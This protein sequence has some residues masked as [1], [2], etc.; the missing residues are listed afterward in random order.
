MSLKSIY[1]SIEN[2]WYDFVEKTGLYKITD[3][4]DKFMPSMLFFILL[5]I[6]IIA[7]IFLLLPISPIGSTNV[8]LI[9]N[10]LE[11]NQ[12]IPSVPV[13]LTGRVSGRQNF[14]T[15]DNGELNFSL[16]KD[17][18]F[19]IDIDYASGNYKRVNNSYTYNDAK[20]GEI[21][22]LLEKEDSTQEL[23]N[24][25]FSLVDEYN[26]RIQN[27]G[28]VE[29]TCSNNNVL[30]PSD[31]DLVNGVVEVLADPNCG[32]RATIYAQGYET[33]YNRLINTETTVISTISTVA[34]FEEDDTYYTI[35]AY[36]KDQITSE[37][38]ENIKFSLYTSTGLKV[39]GSE[40]VTNTGGT[41]N[42]TGVLSG[43]YELRAQ[44]NRTNPIYINKSSN[45]NVNYDTTQT[46]YLSR[47]ITG[48][49]K[50]KVVGNNNIPMD[51]VLLTLKVQDQEISSGRTD[52]NGE[53]L[54]AVSNNGLGYRVVADKE[55]Y[56]IESKAVSAVS[57]M[58]VSPNITIRLTQVTEDTVA[59]INIRV[60]NGNS[61]K[62]YPHAQ[63][64]LY[65]A[66]TGFL[67]DYQA[68]ITDFDGNVSF[69]VA[70][71]KYYA[72]AIKGSS[73][74]KSVDFTFDPK[75]SEI[76]PPVEVV[77]DVSKGQLL[78]SIVNKDN[79]PVPNAKVEIYDKYNRYIPAVGGQLTDAQGLIALDLD[80]DLDVYVVAS[81]PL[82][83]LGITQSDYIKI[84]PNQEA[85]LKVTLY[86]PRSAISNPE[87]EFLGF[88]RGENKLDG[89]L[90]AGQE[91]KARFV[92]FVPSNRSS[93]ESFREVG[94]VI[95][96]GN[97]NSPYLEND[98]IYI[99]EIDVPGAT[100]EKY[101]QYSSSQGYNDKEDV[102]TR[103]LGD[104]KWAKIVIED[105]DY[106]DQE[107]ATAYEIVATVKVRD[108][109]LFGE[110]VEINYLGYG[111][112]RDYTY[113]TD[114][115]YDGSE[116][117][118][119][120]M[121]Y[122]TTPFNI[123]D[124]IVCDDDFCFT[125]TITDIA[126]DLREDVVSNYT[127]APQKDYLLNFGLTNNNNS[128][129]YSQSRF[130]LENEDEG[131]YFVNMNL[132]LP[133]DSQINKTPEAN[134]YN[135]DIATGEFMPRTN[136][137]GEIR[138][139]PI[140]KGDRQIKLEMVSD[141]KVVF[142]KNITIHSLSD[143]TFLVDITPKVIPSGKNF[144]LELEV[145]DATKQI[146][147]NQEVTVTVKDR[148]K[149]TIAGPVTVGA[150]G[151]VSVNNIPGQESGNK[152]YVYVQSPEYE[153]HVSE[154]TT[155]DSIYYITPT[156]LGVSLN[157]NDKTSQDITL[158]IENISE[159][160][161]VVDKI[162]LVGDNDQLEVI[163]VVRIN[164]E[165]LSFIG[166]EIK[167]VDSDSTNNY[168]SKKTFDFSINTNARIQTITELQNL[169]AKIL[170]SL[171]D[172]R[173]SNYVWDEEI[174]LSITV[175][176]DGMFDNSACLTMSEYSIKEVVQSGF[177]EKQFTLKNDCAIKQIPVPLL[178]GLSAKVEFDGTPNGR[179]ILTVGNRLVELSPAY[180][181]TIYDTVDSEKKYPVKL[182]FEPSGRFAGK[183]T[184]KIIFRSNNV[185]TAGAQE[186][187]NSFNFE[188][189]VVN[190]SDC[191]SIPKNVLTINDL[192]KEDSFTIENKGC[193]SET[194][195]RLSCD[196][197]QG[198][199]F[200][201]RENI[202]VSE[203]GT[204]E[205]IKVSALGLTPGIY[206][207]NVHSKIAGAR[208]AEK[209]VGKIR[210][211]VR[212]GT[213]CLDLERYEFDLYRS[214]YSENT[215]LLVNAKSYD[216]T[217]I[218]NRC[219]GQ[220]V[221]VEGKADSGAKW[222]MAILAG[223]RDGLFTGIGSFGLQELG[224]LIGNL[225]G[226]KDK[227]EEK[228]SDKINADFECTGEIK[229][230]QD[231]TTIVC[232][233]NNPI[234]GASY[235]WAIES[236]DGSVTRSSEHI[237]VPNI[238]NDTL[239]IALT[240]K[241]AEKSDKK[242]KEIT[243]GCEDNLTW[244]PAKSICVVD[245]SN[246]TVQEVIDNEDG[247]LNS[248]NPS[249]EDALNPEDAVLDPTLDLWNPTFVCTG[250]TIEGDESS[251]ELFCSAITDKE[252]V[253]YNWSITPSGSE[254]I[255]SENTTISANLS[256]GYVDVILTVS[257]GEEEKTAQDEIFVDCMIGYMWDA[258][259]N[260]C[261]DIIQDPESED[262]TFCESEGYVTA[263]G[264]PYAY[265][266]VSNN[267]NYMVCYEDSQTLGNTEYTFVSNSSLK[268]QICP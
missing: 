110:R 117:E 238:S 263:D 243:I 8:L 64:V 7:G 242:E 155:T 18:D 267:Q 6:I 97:K 100:I 101:T 206:F 226:N 232:K 216:T 24:Y 120:Y 150:L 237:S 20:T 162:E 75:L 246:T 190:L 40:C 133:T 197:C 202:L 105:S 84:Y 55:G 85:N 223:L 194:S 122:N 118:I 175:G 152:V 255:T 168:D 54:F 59:P 170:V 88:F 219:Y 213:G 17:E 249:L 38:L 154:I 163:D 112:T 193:G 137:T 95:R 253:S 116:D 45:I 165:L 98:S 236:N 207:I 77:M 231:S 3:K 130:R 125:L 28:H 2:K 5:L 178:G 259:N 157:V 187:Q 11:T 180:Y 36:A 96:T 81:D 108:T 234:K 266:C 10:D 248:T 191:Y 27:T 89:F 106:S 230:N 189:D 22:I 222:G 93:S 256:H 35:T 167:A 262:Q 209:N 261:V 78:L 37:S 158:A 166:T 57:S 140:L 16:E 33:V 217:N 142:S 82:G 220:I 92:L 182:R 19:V 228:S 126:Q 131:I 127:A 135:F 47:D 58:P 128:K 12:P 52:V 62:G 56:L 233:P 205:E 42:I 172:A 139:R 229:K 244:D 192:G 103:T 156:K 9:V 208:G 29:F 151:L 169:N 258:E 111:Y 70:S 199:M 239:K 132:K 61:G 60:I 121:S 143:K 119:E 48:Y 214:A 43:N 260:K 53:Y 104:S 173:S 184:G 25:T 144:N 177:S 72:Y 240:I 141:Q 268:D 87:I 247:S 241:N 138:F 94:A 63:V 136:L 129:I 31:V 201:P 160:D 185:T 149:N 1:Y 211:Y 34:D 114:P 212:P 13:E 215:G 21:K 67:T 181:K 41:C 159:Q 123:G 224:D 23:V 204:S 254:P 186:I 71:G 164:N 188:Y 147:V 171:K 250:E 99:K 83:N 86:E 109:A 148:F 76:T 146:E 80:A 225:L 14:T 102:D 44:D 74:G 179:F 257:D 73:V 115:S 15:N 251:T 200:N 227:D 153:T 198:L 51:D 107:Y 50:V 196:N 124:E 183:V 203:T 30:A 174:P 39:S 265:K 91:Y 46:I 66:D 49:I 218:I 68:R 113:E 90:K 65:D 32:L 69:N 245:S 235:S 264:Y 252:V 221:S 161:L 176:F 210:V 134:E 26:G 195:Y 79:E 145:K 4:I